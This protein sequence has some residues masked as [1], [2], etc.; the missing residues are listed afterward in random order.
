[1]INVLCCP[2]LHT[3]QAVVS[4][5]VFVCVYYCLTDISTIFVEVKYRR[6]GPKQPAAVAC[7]AAHPL[8]VG[9]V[10]RSIRSPNCVI[11]KVVHDTAMSDERH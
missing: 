7:K 11:A 8:A 2:I 6:G 10:M 4:T 1:M 5:C 9:K 3:K